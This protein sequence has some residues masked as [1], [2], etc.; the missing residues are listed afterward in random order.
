[1]DEDRRKA[2]WRSVE[3]ILA[4]LILFPL[5][6]FI[7]DR[8]GRLHALDDVQSKTDTVTIIKTQFK[9]FPEPTKTVAAGMIAVPKYLFL[10]DSVDRPVPVFIPDTTGKAEDSSGLVYLP[11]EQKY[12][13]EA[14]GQLRMWVSGYQPRLDRWEAD[15]RETT[16]TQTIVEPQARWG[17]SIQAGYGAALMD[18]TVRLSP[19][20]GVGIS[21]MILPIKLPKKKAKKPA[22]ESSEPP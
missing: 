1:M 11:R 4:L 2:I 22:E 17:I 16:V 21:Y 9:D 6:F 18:K 3:W 7:G 19:Y 5:T 13:E 12:Y 10:V 15:F 14:D 20:I 8:Y